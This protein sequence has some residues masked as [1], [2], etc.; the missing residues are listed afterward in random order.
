MILT[1]AL[2]EDTLPDRVWFFT[3]KQDFPRMR[4]E[5]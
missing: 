4:G 2:F 5:R 3:D 1:N